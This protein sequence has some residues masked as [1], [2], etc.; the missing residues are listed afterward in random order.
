MKSCPTCN[1]TF[2]D[3]FTFCLVDGSIL[4][5][6]FDP[7]TTQKMPEPRQTEPPPTE[8]LPAAEVKVPH[9]K[10]WSFRV[11]YSNKSLCVSSVSL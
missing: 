5:A 10:R 11:I 7:Q 3:T 1:R 2:E 6:P 4:S 8:V 9:R